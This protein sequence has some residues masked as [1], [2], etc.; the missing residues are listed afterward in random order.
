MLW[1]AWL[2]GVQALELN[3]EAL[4]QL[5]S[6]EV[7]VEVGPDPQGAA[8]LIEAVIEV[9]TSP[10]KLWDAMVDCERSK[11]T[12]PALKTCRVTERAGDG[13]FDVR[14][15]VVQWVWP[16]PAV[17]TVFRSDYR[18]FASIAF[19]LVEGDLAVMEGDWRLE[20]VRQGAATRL[21][22]RARITPGWPVPGALVRAAL[23]SDIPNTLRALRLEAAGRE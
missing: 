4:A 5:R 17:R 1:L 7:L 15:H 14:E 9:S 19:K 18:P 20:P 12:L 13:S 3:A 6:G 16:L 8:G 2:G 11:R 21:R 23:M 10:R 22:Y